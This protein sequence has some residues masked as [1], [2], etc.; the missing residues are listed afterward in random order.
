M[1]GQAA[2]G[3][4]VVG[5]RSLRS[6]GGDSEVQAVRTE[7]SLRRTLDESFEKDRARNRAVPDIAI[8]RKCGG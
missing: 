8:T 6:G 3:V 4:V 7:N 2:G 5:H 1:Y